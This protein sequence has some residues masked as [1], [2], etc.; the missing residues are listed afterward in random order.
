M[1]EGLWGAAVGVGAIQQFRFLTAPCAMR[2]V[3][4]FALCF[5]F[6]ASSSCA[7][8]CPRAAVMCAFACHS[9]E[10]LHPC[11]NP[12]ALAVEGEPTT[13]WF[14]VAPDGGSRGALEVVRLRRRFPVDLQHSALRRPR[15]SRVVACCPGQ[16]YPATACDCAQR[17][18]WR[19]MVLVHVRRLRVLGRPTFDPT[20]GKCSPLPDLS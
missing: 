20:C 18:G 16:G 10:A 7:A 2:V 13:P 4:G 12:C 17:G 8:E 15:H 5:E 9:T 3:L 11:I 14:C 19:S 1:C 6:S